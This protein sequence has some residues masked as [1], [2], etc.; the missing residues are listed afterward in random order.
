ML[1]VLALGGT[2]LLLAGCE[3]TD[4][5]RDPSPTGT[6]VPDDPQTWPDDSRLLMATRQ[7]IHV[8]RVNLAAT[9]AARRSTEVAALDRLWGLQIDRL[10]LL[11]TLG[12]LSLPELLTPS[13][14][15][16][17]PDDEAG[18]SEADAGS[19]SAPPDDGSATGA[20]RPEPV[21]VAR[22]LRGQLPP[23]MREVATATA[24][25]LA[26]L[27]SLAAQHADAADRLGAPVEWAPLVGPAGAAAV[28]V[29]AVTRPAVFGFE[30]LAARSREEERAG[31]ERILEELRSLTRQL[32]TLAGDAAPVA[33][34]GYD[35]PE[36]LETADERRALARDLVADL[37]PAG[38]AAAER[39][40]GDAAALTGAVRIVAEA[41]GW[42]R[43]LGAAPEPFPGMTLP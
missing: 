23:V 19:T 3:D 36:P 17:P 8:H 2:A 1:R 38:L 25:N 24:T 30:V 33:P 37:A 28:P 26:M 34:L 11:I 27:V 32:T 40:R 35:L 12:G 9:A 18:T 29:L 10:G 16:R 43:E 20:T 15:D 13:V 6:V 39:L 42:A 14:V 7:R 31:Y 4:E 21:D 5:G 41:A 22:A